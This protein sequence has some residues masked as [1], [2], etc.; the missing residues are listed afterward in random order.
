MIKYIQGDLFETEADIIAHG[1]NAQGVM[2][3]GVAKTIRDKYP[4]AYH[5]YRRWH[6]D[7]GLELGSVV[8]ATSNKKHIANCITQE[9]YGRDGR[10][11]V[12]YLAVRNCMMKIY[13]YSLTTPVLSVAMPR[14]G[15]GLG[16]GDWNK[17]E[18]I[19][20]EEFKDKEVLVY[21]PK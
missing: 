5:E 11:Y 4:E 7:Y 9:Y 17:I 2:G 18:Q 15:A 20:N 13:L 1:C 8:W 10:V 6:E 21:I 12:D 3:S 14:I 19:I 16:G